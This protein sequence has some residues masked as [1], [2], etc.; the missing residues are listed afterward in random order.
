VTKRTTYHPLNGRGYGHVT[1][2]VLPW[3]R[4]SATA[5]PVVSFSCDFGQLQSHFV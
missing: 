1:F 5:E 3:C 2:K 4:S